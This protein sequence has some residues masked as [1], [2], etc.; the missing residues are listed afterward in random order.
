MTGFRFCGFLPNSSSLPFVTLS[1]Y[2]ATDSMKA[3]SGTSSFAFKIFA[4][5]LERVRAEG[6]TVLDDLLR[7]SLFGLNLLEHFSS[8]TQRSTLF[9]CLRTASAMT[10]RRWSSATNLFPSRL[11]KRA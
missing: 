1:L 7:H 9:F 11:T 10:S 8:A 5:L 3:C 2:F 4:S 6:E